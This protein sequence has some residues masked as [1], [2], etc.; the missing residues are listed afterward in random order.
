MVVD[1]GNGYGGVLPLGVGKGICGSNREKRWGMKAENV[2][3]SIS[4]LD[5]VK[6]VDGV[7]AGSLDSSLGD[8]DDGVNSSCRRER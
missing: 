8:C 7:G 5:G 2:A 6:S 4:S 1:G 3:G